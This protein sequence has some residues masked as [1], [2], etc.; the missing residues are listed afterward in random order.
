M[1]GARG[2]AGS[3][4]PPCRPAPVFDPAG[5]PGTP[6]APDDPAPGPTGYP[7]SRSIRGQELATTP[8]M[9]GPGIA[10]L[11]GAVGRCIAHLGLVV[12]L[13]SHAAGCLADDPG[14]PDCELDQCESA[15]SRDEVL[16]AIDGHGDAIAGYLRDAVSERGTLA[17]DYRDVLDGVGSA[18]GCAPETEKSFVVLSNTGFIPKTVFARCADDP[19]MASRFF[20]AVPAVRDAGSDTDVDPQVLHLSAWD[21][22]AGTYRIYSTRPV[23]GGEMGVNVSPSFCL[24]CHGGP[25]QLPYWQPLMNE[26]TNPWSGWNAEPGFRSQLFDEFLDPGIA[27]GPVYQDITADDLLD[28]ASNLEPIIRAG[29]ERLNGARVLAREQ[30]L[31]V[32]QALSLLQPMYCDESINF[33]SE[34][35]GG[36]QIRS[37]AVIDPAVATHMRAA[38]TAIDW[39]WATGD[40]LRLASAPSEWEA[41]TLVPVRGES[42]LAV[43][44][45]LVSRQVLDPL[46]ALRVRALDWTRP[47][48]SEFRCALFRAGVERIRAGALDAR[49][50]EL[51]EGSNTA[52]LLPL[53]YDEIMKS[54]GADGVVALVPPADAD[55]IAIPDASHPDVEARLA[56]GD[57]SQF[58]ISVAEFGDRIQ[59]HVEATDRADLRAIRQ[60]RACRALEEY[61]ITPIYPDLDCD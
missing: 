19:Q 27:E 7:T 34:I 2:P 23:D 32:D 6:K 37:S 49:I 39:P 41:L 11:D 15:Q 60:V 22:Q 44:V 29:I 53:A 1:N 31:D 40:D 56:D 47:V 38:G 52:D 45:S 55:V 8:R 51:P 48:L 3:P 17:G 57:L 5:R 10:P 43:E 25:Q 50:A 24:G 28:S 9:A 35:H 30:A 42:S 4:F 20:L 16:A 33:V 46:Q 18:L 36:G 12:L 61:A 58:A 59:A 14:A 13:V 26:M 21:E 54:S